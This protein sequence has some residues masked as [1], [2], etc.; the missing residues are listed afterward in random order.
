[1]ADISNVKPPAIKELYERLES[2]SCT[3][4]SPPISLTIPPRL[5]TRTSENHDPD[6]VLIYSTFS[7]MIRICNYLL[8][9]TT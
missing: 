9:N 8:F 3:P 1:M 4:F 5:T 6:S 7:P 2:L